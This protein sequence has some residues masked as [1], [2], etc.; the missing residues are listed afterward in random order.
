MK[1]VIPKHEWEAASQLMS[2][3]AVDET[4]ALGQ[5]RLQCNGEG[6]RWCATDWFRLATVE[7]GSD[8]GVYDVGLSVALVR[9]AVEVCGDE[10]VTLEIPDDGEERMLAVAGDSGTMEMYDLGHD[11]PDIESFLQPCD[12]IMGSASVEAGALYDLVSVATTLREVDDT[13]GAQVGFQAPLFLRIS[14]GELGCRVEW[15]T[16]GSTD[17]T[18]AEPGARGDVIVRVTPAYLQSL[19]AMWRRHDEVMIEIPRFATEP[20]R[21][22]GAGRRAALMP[23]ETPRQKLRKQVEVT[24]REVC[25]HLSVIRDADGDYP[26]RRHAVPIYGRLL[27]DESS[28]F[29]VFAVVLNNL[30]ASPEVYSE[31]NDLNSNLQFARLFHVEGQV[32]AEVDLVAETLDEA[33][34][35]VA[36]ERLDHVTLRI[37]PTLAAVFGGE[38]ATDPAEGRLDAYRTAIIDA[39]V[40]PGSL[41]P[42]NGPDA[43]AAWPFPG[44]VHVLTA[45]NPQG[46]ALDADFTA[47]INNRIAEDIVRSGGRFVHGQGRSPDGEHVEPSIVAWGLSRDDARSM[48]R[49]ASQDSVFEIDESF[50]HLL[51]C[52][53]DRVESWLRTT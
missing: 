47:G 25:G 14:D 9:Y 19:L 52:I 40:L 24:L 26:L 12:D 33:E 32:L 22:R 39:E 4:D 20:I 7:G 17:F 6:R 36:I 15:P 46:V 28:V 35:N 13:G 3:I 34:L 21:L 31:L 37:G 49:K 38:L 50:V 45:W 23:V 18:L 10:D 53:D 44:P 30:D 51:S 8:R 1:I 5:I 16:I 43:V 48:G 2:I 29:Q 42:L 27:F 41:S 11:F